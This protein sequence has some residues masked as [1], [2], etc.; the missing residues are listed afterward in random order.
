MAE[1]KWK[2]GRRIYFSVTLEDD[3]QILILLLGGNKNG[4][5]RDIRKAKLILQK[6][7]GDDYEQI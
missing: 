1:L 7:T 4:Q 3:G 2:N 6:L 5:N